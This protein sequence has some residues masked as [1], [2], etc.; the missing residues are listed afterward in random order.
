MPVPHPVTRQDGT[1]AWRVR[2][3]LEGQRNP[4]CQTFTRR[5]DAERF[6]HLVSLVGGRAARAAWSARQSGATWPGAARSG[7]DVVV[8]PTLAQAVADYCSLL[9]ASDAPGT[10]R[11]YRTIADQHINPYLGAFPLDLITHEHVAGL[12][13]RLRTTPVA[14]GRRAGQP[15]AASTVNRILQLLSSVMT[16]YVRLGVITANPAFKVRVPRDAA[17]VEHVF[18]TPT[19]VRSLI[20]A[21][22]PHWRTLIAT[23]YGTG[24]R[25]GEAV[26]LTPADL[27][28]EAPVPVVRVT[29]TWRQDDGGY[30]AA[31]KTVAGLR[32][33]SLPGTLVPLLR[34]Q[35]ADAD[36]SGPLF[37]YPDGS[38]RHV[39]R[40][41]FHR[42]VWQPAVRAAGLVPAPRVHDLRHSHASALIAAG[43]PLTV[44]QRRLG[45]TSI[46]ITSDIY[47]HLAP[48]ALAQAA[49]A[50]DMPLARALRQ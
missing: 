23:L 27:D 7:G 30:A 13:K 16:H 44:I 1:V 29:K 28:L 36:A 10:V 8:P 50:I 48:D 3:R 26:A 32:A 31:P 9:E 47:G 46:K 15:L 24:I 41:A 6:A 22:P 37:S 39:L 25:F 49:S 20:A 40:A 19:Q 43:V 42:S 21:A 2:F 18:L 11:A 33:V 35:A 17:S 45:H 4:V 14:R 12:A 38:G 34:A 5:E